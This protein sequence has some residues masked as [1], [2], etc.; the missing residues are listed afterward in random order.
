MRFNRRRASGCVIR[1][2][3]AASSSNGIVVAIADSCLSPLCKCAVYTYTH[4]TSAAVPLSVRQFVTYLSI[5]SFINNAKGVM[6]SN[7][8][9]TIVAVSQRAVFLCPVSMC[10]YECTC[11]SAIV[12]IGFA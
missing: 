10:A 12:S 4:C 6:S 3:S 8:T 7:R 5:Q 9:R 11:M 2:S 1:F